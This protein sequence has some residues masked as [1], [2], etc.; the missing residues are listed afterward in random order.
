MI[1]PDFEREIQAVQ[2]V[3]AIYECIYDEFVN[4]AS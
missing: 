3:V 4:R 1:S 2:L